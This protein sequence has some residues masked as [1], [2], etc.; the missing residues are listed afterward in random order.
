MTVRAGVEQH[1]FAR[2]DFEGVIDGVST[3]ARKTFP[4]VLGCLLVLTAVMFALSCKSSSVAFRADGRVSSLSIQVA[5]TPSERAAGLA[6]RAGLPADGGMLFD[7][8]ADSTSAFWMKDTSIPL[9]IAFIGSDGKVLAVKDMKPFDETPVKPPA[10]YRY[11]I[12]VNQGWFASHGVKQGATAL[13]D[14]RH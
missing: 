2:V 1:T 7:F 12:E 6:N 8:G 9:S 3:F 11:A 5:D 4:Y 13:I 14:E 10:P